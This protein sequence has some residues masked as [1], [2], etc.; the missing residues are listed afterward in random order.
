MWVWI[1]LP[2]NNTKDSQ[3]ARCGVTLGLEEHGERHLSTPSRIQMELLHS[4]IWWSQGLELINKDFTYSKTLHIHRK[5][6]QCV[7]YVWDSEHPNFLTWDKVQEK[8]KLMSNEAKE[9]A[10]LTNKFF[11]RWWH[12]L[13]VDSD[14]THPGDWIG[15]YKV[16]EEDPVLVL[17]CVTSFTPPCIQLRHL[18][19]PLPVQC[20]I[21][22]TH[23]IG[24]REWE[25][26]IGNMVGFSYKLKIIY[27]IG[28]Q[29][30]EK[31]KESSFSMI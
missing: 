28:G 31:M 2:V 1:G 27:T 21:V 10:R 13:D 22:G 25:S 9:W 3:D 14:A 15:L 7:H 24:L 6:I 4:K 23:P 16:G 19:M 8:F 18:F 30:F 12:L 29:K 5:G 17:Q 11:G 26:P 20:F